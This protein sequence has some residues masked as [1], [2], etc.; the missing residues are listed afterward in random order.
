[1]AP[2][3]GL[4][5][6]LNPNCIKMNFQEK[7]KAKRHSSKK[8]V[9]IDG[10]HHPTYIVE[11]IYMAHILNTR[12][13]ADI[14]FIDE[15]NSFSSEVYRALNY[16]P[17]NITELNKSI[18]LKSALHYKIDKLLLK[19]FK[20]ELP[21]MKIDDLFVGD[22]VT[23][24]V[25][26]YSSDKYTLDFSCSKFDGTIKNAYYYYHRNLKI[27]QKYKLTDSFLSHADYL[28]FGIL[29]R[30]GLKYNVKSYLHLKGGIFKVE[31]E[32]EIYF[33]RFHVSEPMYKELMKIDSEVLKSYIDKRFKGEEKLFSADE[34]FRKD[35]R[36]VNRAEFV[37]DLDMNPDLP[38]CTIYLH[39]FADA[40]H[41][42]QKM[43]YRSYFEWCMETISIIKTI[44]HVNWVVKDHP[45]AC[46]YDETG[47]VPALMKKNNVKYVPEN[48]NAKSVLEISDSIVT[49]RGTVGLEAPIFNIK[50]ILAGYSY[51]SMFGF[52]INCE[53]REEYYKAL[54][55]ITFKTKL[56]D[57]H[58]DIAI[59]MLY[60][61]A[62]LIAAKS[63]IIDYNVQGGGYEETK[64]GFNRYI[65]EIEKIGGIEHDIF[66]KNLIKY[67]AD[68]DNKSLT[69][70]GVL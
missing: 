34:P 14:Y 39:A 53:T 2:H 26:R 37:K 18:K 28:Y 47:I 61:T 51:Y 36:V 45:L 8:R 7:Y 25:L 22:L 50:P 31:E 6:C 20:K 59:R 11:F 27:I 60:W 64:R 55:S 3:A 23:D 12:Y 35:K 19:F 15:P 4:R 46:M 29:P 63:D 67:F 24:T 32:N 66:Y 70:F 38:I 17:I 44:G 33:S 62:E 40:N 52:T 13:E 56:S 48:Y 42:E 41:Y 5:I 10:F 1:M 49:V 65:E 58:K 9:F 21:E 68:N 43:I 54:S 30:L 16:I 69:G 57:E